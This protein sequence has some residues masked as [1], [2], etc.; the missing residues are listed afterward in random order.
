MPYT[1]SNT[2]SERLTI[3]F[4]A[5]CPPLSEQLASIALPTEKIDQWQ[6]MADSIVRLHV[7]NILSDSKVEKARS[8]LMKRI[9]AE[10]DRLQCKEGK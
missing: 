1:Y 10:M 2:M 9:A 8:R 6:M 7:H 4:G 3:H 5:M